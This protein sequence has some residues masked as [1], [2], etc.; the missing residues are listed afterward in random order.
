M[1]PVTGQSGSTRNLAVRHKKKANSNS[2]ISVL[3]YRGFALNLTVLAR[4]V[5]SLR[6]WTHNKARQE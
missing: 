6:R 3:Q 4:D 5:P 1:L 2:F